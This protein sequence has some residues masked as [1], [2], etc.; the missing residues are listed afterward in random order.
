MEQAMK[1]PA[2]IKGCRVPSGANL[3]RPNGSRWAVRD[4]KVLWIHQLL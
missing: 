4:P 2:V 1:T 3:I